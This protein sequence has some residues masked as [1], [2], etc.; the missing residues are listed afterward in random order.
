MRVKY[1]LLSLG[2]KEIETLWLDFI[3]RK[4]EILSLSP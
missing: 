4:D 1:F 2:D 3:L